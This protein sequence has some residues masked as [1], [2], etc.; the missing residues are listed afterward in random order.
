MKLWLEILAK[1]G[2]NQQVMQTSF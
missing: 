2:L 1:H